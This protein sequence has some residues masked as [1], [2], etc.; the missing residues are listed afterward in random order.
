METLTLSVEIHADR[1]L[2]IDIPADFPIGVVELTIRRPDSALPIQI[3]PEREALRA[4]LLAAGLL[5]T[6]YEIPLGAVPLSEDALMEMGRL[7]DLI[8]TFV[9]S[10]NHF[11]IV[12]VV[13]EL[14]LCR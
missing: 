14:C 1:R 9:F 7:R 5:E 8:G 12:A 2:V 3:N 10:N 6:S 13:L 11:A 4:K